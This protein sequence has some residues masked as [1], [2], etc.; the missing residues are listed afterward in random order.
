M[1]QVVTKGDGLGE[2]LVQVQGTRDGTA[3]LGYLKG[4]GEPGYIV[5]ARWCDEYLRFMLQAAECLAVY[6]PVA[7]ALKCGTHGT[8][9][10]IKLPAPRQPALCGV[11]RKAF[12]PFLEP[13][14]N[15]NR[16]RHFYGTSGW[17]FASNLEGGKRL[18]AGRLC[19]AFLI[20]AFSCITL[21]L[22]L[23]GQSMPFLTLS[24]KWSG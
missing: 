21:A 4:M 7:I 22:G 13:M 19:G 16:G 1:A 18:A 20:K 23:E 3:D 11:R 15:I 17:V 10:F 24:T 6:D 14:A 5:I 9:L 8:G 2:I 12:F